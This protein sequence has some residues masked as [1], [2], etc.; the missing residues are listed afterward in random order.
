MKKNGSYLLI[1][2]VIILSTVI[3][4][5]SNVSISAIADNFNWSV[6]LIMVSMELFT[7]IV[8]ETGV[9]EKVSLKMGVFSKGS[10]KICVVLFGMMMFLTSAV[11][12]N[13][14]AV[15]MTLPIILLL[16]R[17]IGADKKYISL[18]FSVILAASNLGGM[19][20]PIGD[21]PALIVMSS[22]I[23]S[24]R[25]YLSSSFPLAF[26]S[27]IVLI[28]IWTLFVE[29][30]DTS[31][32][33]RMFAVEI[34]NS[35][36]RNNKVKLDVLF[37]VMVVFMLML[38]VWCIVPSSV[39]PTEMV[40]I[41]GYVLVMSIAAMKGIAIR[42]CIDIK[43]LLTIG[44]FLYL[45]DVVSSTGLL[46]DLA[47]ILQNS[48][49]DSKLLLL[50][51]MLVTSIV[52]GLV[53]AGPA[54]AAL[55]PIVVNLSNTAFVGQSNIVATAFAASICSGSSLFLWSA[56]AGFLL[57]DKISKANLSS[58]NEKVKWSIMEYFRYGLMNYMVQ[59]AIAIVWVLFTI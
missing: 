18:F 12:N 34:L 56:T 21:A 23:T 39:I 40:A 22:K 14:T 31:P 47:N 37:P 42:Q 52:S 43:T 7:N 1:T 24:F 53:S 8:L 13:I 33:Q 45:A 41:L 46:I 59:I 6:L 48:I 5:I 30:E 55:L 32:E 28:S 36:Y 2:T 51:I 54:T 49:V 29:K 35:K 9:M 25:G 50:V 15:M 27:A 19:A 38:V 58:D 11:L 10:K 20:T 4:I 16:L 44:S 57:S 26:F 17:A 3:A